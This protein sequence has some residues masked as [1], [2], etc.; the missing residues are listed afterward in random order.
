MPQPIV[1][2][3]I[4]QFDTEF[5][6]AALSKLQSELK[7]VEKQIEVVQKRLSDPNQA[8]TANVFN[9]QLEALQKKRADLIAQSA[10]F[11]AAL[12][13]NDTAMKKIGT[14]SAL[15]SKALNALKSALAIGAIVDFT[16]RA[17]KA[18]AEL[19]KTTRSFQAFGVS[20]S[21][22]KGIVED[23]NT[24]AGK[25]PFESEDLNSTAIKLVSF[26]VAA[27]DVL[28]NVEALSAIAAGS[29]ASLNTLSEAFGRAKQN[30]SL[31]SIDFRTLSKQ[32]PGF[33]EA[34][35][36][37]TGKT[38]NE[39]TK[40]GK[41]GQISFKDF[42]EAVQISTSE[43]GKFGKVISSYQD[44][45][46]GLGK[47]VKELGTNLLTAF[48]GQATEGIK[49]FLKS[50]IENK[51]GILNFFSS[52]G[53]VIG[54]VANSLGFFVNIA[55]KAF[56][57]IDALGDKLDKFLGIGEFSQSAVKENIKKV[58]DTVFGTL[59]D[60]INDTIT[61][62][63]AEGVKQATDAEMK[64]AEERA[65]RLAEARKKFIE[66][67]IRF[68]QTLSDIESD[69][70]RETL[71][72]QGLDLFAEISKVQEDSAKKIQD[73]SKQLTE[74]QQT[75]KQAGKAVPNELVKR[76]QADIKIVGDSAIAAIDELSKQFLAPVQIIDSLKLLIPSA[77][78]EFDGILARK[79]ASESLK[80]I[81]NQIVE[82]NLDANGD[83]KAAK[84]ANAK[85]GSS[86]LGRLLGID[87]NSNT[88][89]DDL[90]KFG[91]TFKDQLSVFSSNAINAADT[92]INAELQ[93]TG[94]LISETEKRLQ[95]LL[96][97]QEGGNSSQIRLEQDR[98]DKLND[99]RQ[100][101]VERQKAID[102]AQI[103]ANNAVSASESIKAI[104]TAFGKGGNPIVGIAASLALVATIAATVASVNAQ[105][106]S[107]PRFWEG[108]ERVSDKSRPTKSGR[109]GHLL[110]ADGG[111]RIIPTKFNAQIPSYVKNK[112]IPSLVEMGIR[113]S[114]GGM[115]DR[116]ITIRQDETNRLLRSNQKLLKNQ[117]IKLKILNDSG[118]QL[119]LKRMAR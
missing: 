60:E 39:V 29:G 67:E 52:L 48:G 5:D 79:S 115:T 73:L 37:A 113:A 77:E 23:L 47:G 49:N 114:E 42:N 96:S 85:A 45:L 87:P 55:V 21:K 106:N 98:L 17:A 41:Q 19:E 9:V 71:S 63:A 82:D 15:A 30:G 74:L 88:A 10:K 66:D 99:Q 110:W 43:T 44:S 91:K 4:F 101:F 18:T 22:A 34:I 57:Y 119:R 25:V 94:F 102:A 69:L 112:D 14:S 24:L 53:K 81:I 62:K 1:Q 90:E 70:F 7:A 64:A 78:L 26:G 84:T 50:I 59:F 51:D 54:Y 31:A 118:E 68:R 117:T 111:E 95:Q 75:A 35:S 80:K 89:A 27:K 103:I 92:F 58:T 28:N 97:I 61:K 46:G 76:V 56:G 38:I 100:K 93:K 107:I 16:V 116:N 36:Q 65:K 109:D 20:A 3:V 12:N 83:I 108:A 11:D 32:I 2:S 86:F 33:V 8:K 105:F 13:S 40:L 72:K 104:T 6:Q